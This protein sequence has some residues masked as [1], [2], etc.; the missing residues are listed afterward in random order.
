MA[1]CSVKAQ[2]QRLP[3]QA[4]IHK[5]DNKTAIKVKIVM[6]EMEL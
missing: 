6:E 3:L 2:G 1:W 4:S 5:S